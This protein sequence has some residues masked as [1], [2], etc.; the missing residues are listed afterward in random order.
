MTTMLLVIPN[1]GT[2]GVGKGFWF[3]LYHQE[4]TLRVVIKI[5]GSGTAPPGL[6]SEKP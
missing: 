3:A 1:S 2:Q 5:P 4:K 6:N